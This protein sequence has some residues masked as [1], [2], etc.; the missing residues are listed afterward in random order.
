[1]NVAFM[2]SDAIIAGAWKAARQR[3]EK[4]RGEGAYLLDSGVILNVSTGPEPVGAK[5][6]GEFSTK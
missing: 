2:F 5:S 1:M 3:L 6:E 4:G